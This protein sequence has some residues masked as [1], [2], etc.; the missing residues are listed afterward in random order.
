MK[1]VRE[2]DIGAR[3]GW[4]NSVWKVRTRGTTY[5]EAQDEQFSTFQMFQERPAHGDPSW[6]TEVRLIGEPEA[7]NEPW[8]PRELIESLSKWHP[9]QPIEVAFSN[10]RA[11]PFDL[12]IS[13]VQNNNTILLTKG[14]A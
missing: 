9:D 13:L 6:F 12:D 5:V 3:F 10:N 2:L 8:T 11:K 7:G 4:R 14:R 1:Q